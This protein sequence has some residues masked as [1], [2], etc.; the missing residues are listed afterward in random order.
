MAARPLNIQDPS[1]LNHMRLMDAQVFAQAAALYRVY[2]AVRR[3]NTAALQ[4]IGKPRYIPK[5][6]DCKAKTAD[7]DVIVNGKLYKTAGLVVD[8]TIVGNGAY[9]GGKHAK[10][11]SEW[12]KFR[13]HL[14][15]AVAASGQ[16]PMYLPAHR[17]YLVQTDPS[18]IHYGCVMHCKSGLRT[19][20]HFVHGD[21]D[22]FSVVPVGDKVSNVFVEEER[23]GVP[24]ARGKDLLDVQTYINARIGSPMVRH[25]EQEHFSD[26]ADEEID[27]FFPDGVTVKSYLNAAA[28]RELYAQEFAGRTLH[29][30]GTQTTSA[31]GLWKRG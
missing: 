28:I 7:F 13:P 19:A 18:H 4:Y 9:K 14:G 11:L 26:S 20:G 24:H 23:M 16:P 12:E 29:Q 30:A 1:L 5:M 8:P 15:P 27:V 31:G 22:L 3:T 6:L 25:G 17:S 2:I 21:Y 10:A